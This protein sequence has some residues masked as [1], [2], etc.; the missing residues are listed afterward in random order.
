MKIEQISIT[1]MK[2]ITSPVRDQKYI[3]KR[4][5]TT[6]EQ[7]KRLN[8]YDFSLNNLKEKIHLFISFYFP[9]RLKS[10]STL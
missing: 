3:V 4:D 10:E 6:L 1:I 2:R 5:K 7:N 9:Y 8:K